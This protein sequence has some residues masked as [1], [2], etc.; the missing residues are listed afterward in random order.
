MDMEPSRSKLDPNDIPILDLD[1]D[2][3]VDDLDI[4]EEQA[5]KV[6]TYKDFVNNDE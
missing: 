4:L 2:I 3:G 5:Y 6:I 1:A